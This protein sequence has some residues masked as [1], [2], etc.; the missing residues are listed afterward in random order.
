MSMVYLLHIFNIL[1]Y[2]P[3]LNALYLPEIFIKHQE[4]QREVTLYS[5][6]KYRV[7]MP[8]SQI[9]WSLI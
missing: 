8:E 9:K 1:K 3:I 4:P 7:K 2:V 5:E 6:S